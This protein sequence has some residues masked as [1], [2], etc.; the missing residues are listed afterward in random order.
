[1]NIRL[2]KQF[3]VGVAVLALSVLVV[4]VNNARRETI[5]RSCKLLQTAN[6]LVSGVVLNGIEATRRHYYYYYYYYDEG[7]GRG[8]RR[9]Y[10][11]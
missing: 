4:S 5:Q 7:A 1:M 6:A 10:H 11:F 8:H 2:T 3:V 9:W